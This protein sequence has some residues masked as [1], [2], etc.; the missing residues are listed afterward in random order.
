MKQID[1]KTINKFGEHYL[2]GVNK[3]GE[4][5]YLEKESWDCGWYWGFGYLHTYTNDRCPTQSKDISMHTHFDSL[6]LNKN[7]NAYDLINGYFE[8]MVISKD[9][10]Y[11]LV[12]LMMTMYDLKKTAE[13][14]RHGYSYQ[15]EKAKIEDLKDEA[16]ENRINKVLLPQVFDRIRKLL[17]EEN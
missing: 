9:Q 5:V 15:T 14:F 12:D 10:L 17:T 4:H 2:L 3:D 8:S 6:F 16:L 11:E 7:V 1:K 13:L